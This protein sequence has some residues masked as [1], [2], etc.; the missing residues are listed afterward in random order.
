VWLLCVIVTFDGIAQ[1]IYHLPADQRSRQSS[2]CRTSDARPGISEAAKTGGPI[3]FKGPQ[4]GGG[5]NQLGT[6]ISNGCTCDVQIGDVIATKSGMTFGPVRDAVNGLITSGSLPASITGSESQ[7]VTVPIVDW[8]SSKSGASQVTVL[9]FAEIWL[10]SI[11]QVQGN[12]VL[13]VQFVQYLAPEATRGGGT[14]SYGAYAAPY[15]V[16]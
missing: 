14:T 16:L 4:N 8:G 9:G 13:T 10:D 3:E 7:L 11:T 6:N 2:C 1:L 15:L 5:G 12:Q